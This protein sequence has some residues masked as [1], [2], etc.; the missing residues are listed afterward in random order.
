MKKLT[1]FMFFCSIS[2]CLHAQNLY[3]DLKKI[4]VISP[5]ISTILR[6]YQSECSRNRFFYEDK[7]IV[8]V[9]VFQDSLNRQVYRLS[10]LIDDRYLDNP[11]NEYLTI[12]ADVFLFYHGDKE[13]NEIKNV[14]KNNEIE[15][16]KKLVGDRVYIRPLKAD[17]WVEYQGIN[18]QTL[19]T[20]TRTIYAG[21]IW[22]VTD[23]IFTSESKF[24]TLKQL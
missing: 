11:T 23:Y 17:R 19:R 10:A 6:E 9:V 7:G 3:A 4:D 16:L 1:I 8:K 24:E 5:V 14:L 15:C 21:N 18:N 13:G 12:G 20:K 22:N 2:I